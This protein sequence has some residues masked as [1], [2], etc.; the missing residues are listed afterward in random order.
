MLGRPYTYGS[1][2]NREY[3]TVRSYL[4]PSVRQEEVLSSEMKSDTE[5]GA[6]MFA[7]SN[8]IARGL[9]EDEVEMHSYKGAKSL[10]NT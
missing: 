1:G 6:L 10:V 3:T 4:A 9:Q 5:K 8:C 7:Q 2:G